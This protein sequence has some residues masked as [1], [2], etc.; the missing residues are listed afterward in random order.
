MATEPNKARCSGLRYYLFEGV[1]ELPVE[2]EWRGPLARRE[3][4]FSRDMVSCRTRSLL[5][6]RDW[7]APLSAYRGVLKKRRKYGKNSYLYMVILKHAG[8]PAEDVVL[9]Q[10]TAPENLRTRQEECARLLELPALIETDEGILERTPAELDRTVRQRVADGSL[11][12]RFD[13]ASGPPGSGLSVRIEGDA[14]LLR[15]R[16]SALNYLLVAPLL[17][18]GLVVL[19]S[20]TRGMDVLRR[21][22]AWVGVVCAAIGLGGVGW[23]LLVVEELLV[24]PHQVRRRFTTAWG[25]F[26]EEAVP[27]DEVEEVYSGKSPDGIGGNRVQFVADSGAVS[28]GTSLTKAQRHWV[29]DCVIAVLSR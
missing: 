10:S 2:V 20:G 7:E 28:F 27:S 19:L 8:P 1:G 6:R 23:Q 3:Y 12:V 17:L 21:A 11:E 29:R 15:S 13:P 5:R 9:Y 14:L 22:P 16:P 26:A 4:A 24:S 25:S 18:F